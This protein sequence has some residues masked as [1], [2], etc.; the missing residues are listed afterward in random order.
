MTAAFGGVLFGASMFV[1]PLT[2]VV[3]SAATAPILILVGTLMAFDLVTAC[4]AHLVAMIPES[5][6]PLDVADVMVTPQDELAGGR[7]STIW[8]PVGI[9]SRWGICLPTW[10]VGD[11]VARVS[12][13]P[14]A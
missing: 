11:P 3:P 4:L 12:R 1:W 8:W 13:R 14:S 2:S 6:H 7:R 9:H 5:A 10:A